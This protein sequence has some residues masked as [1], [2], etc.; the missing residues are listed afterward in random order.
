MNDL[1]NTF[2][3]LVE[4]D[5]KAQLKANGLDCEAN[6]Q[7]AN[8]TVK[9][10][11]KYTKV[12]IGYSGRYM[13]ENSTGNIYGIKGYGV[14]HKGHFYGHLNDMNNW[15]WGHYYPQHKTAPIPTNVNGIPKT[16]T[17]P[18]VVNA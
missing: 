9:P 10:G 6:I 4:T 14:I 13:I 17:A 7:N 2:A 18:E 1:I 12:N 16:T 8:T 5:T 15:F 3:Q 11:K